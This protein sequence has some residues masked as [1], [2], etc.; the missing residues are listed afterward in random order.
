MPRGAAAR[1]APGLLALPRQRGPALR[2]RAP[3]AERVAI[4]LPGAAVEHA[5]EVDRFA[6][7]ADGT[8]A[9]AVAA[10]IEPAATLDVGV[11]LS[12]VTFD[13]LE[14]VDVD[15]ARLTAIGALLAAAE[16]VGAAERML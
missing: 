15:V 16:S 5:D 10:S 2:R 7:V 3:T 13:H 8:V 6:V 9:L 4:A 14:P 1:R 11:P 12:T